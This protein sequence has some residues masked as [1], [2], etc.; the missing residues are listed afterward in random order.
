MSRFIYILG[1]R[2]LHPF[3]YQIKDLLRIV[4]QMYR[5]HKRAK[6]RFTITRFGIVE[7]MGKSG[8]NGTAAI[9]RNAMHLGSIIS[10]PLI[11]RLLL[12][13]MG[14]AA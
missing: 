5:S 7:P 1:A 2:F 13:K 11:W 3:S 14:C 10:T 9:D 4:S 12:R 6:R 8:A